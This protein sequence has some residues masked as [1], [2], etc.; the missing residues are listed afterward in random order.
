M[1]GQKLATEIPKPSL[2]F[3]VGSSSVGALP[4]C[5]PARE[6]AANAPRACDSGCD[7]RYQHIVKGERRTAMG[8]VAYLAI[9]AV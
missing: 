8:V 4:N 6:L 9:L 7:D 1:A 3:G 5:T 2:D